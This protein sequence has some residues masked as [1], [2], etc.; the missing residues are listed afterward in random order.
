MTQIS[1][2]VWSLT[3]SQT[4]WK[5]KSYG[6]EEA[7]TQTKL[8]EVMG[9]QLSYFKSENMMLWKCWTQYASKFGKLSSGHRTGKGQFSLLSHEKQCQRTF[10]LTHNGTNLTCYQMNSPNS[11]SQ[12]STVC[13]LRT[14]RCS[15]WIQQRQRNQFQKNICFI[16]YT[17]AFEC[18]D[19]NKLWN[20]LK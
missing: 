16:D 11:L 14:S 12:A 9:F 8:V 15:S 13:E 10:K 19:H 18:V 20:I 4:S 3:Q 6:P 17:K 1:T 5:Q 7:S 2:M